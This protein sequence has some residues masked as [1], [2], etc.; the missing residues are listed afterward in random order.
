MSLRFRLLMAI[1]LALLISFS[2]G[3]ALAAWHAASS[4]HEELSSS[5]AIARQGSLAALR[6]L[7]QGPSGEAELRRMV[8]AYDGSR[9]VRAALLAPDGTVLQVST[10]AAAKKPPAWFLRLVSP[11]VKT[12]SA[13]VPGLGEFRLTAV[14][15]SEAAERWT[16]LRERLAG[17]GLFFLVAALLCSATVGRSLRPLTALTQGLA[18]VGRGELQA[19]LPQAGPPEIA[20]L[21]GAFNRMAADLRSAEAQNRRLSQQILTIA[22]EERAEIARDLHDDIGP[23]LFA[24]TNFAASIGRMIET[25]DL[26]AVPPQLRAIQDA[27]AQVQREVRDML[28][29]LHQGS[30]GPPRLDAALQELAVFWRAVRPAISLDVDCVIP[31]AVLTDQARECLFRVAQ[32]GISNAVRHG[33]PRN[34]RVDASLRNGAAILSVSD[35]GAVQTAVSGA[36]PGLGLAGMRARAASLGGRIDIVRDRGWKVSVTLPVEGA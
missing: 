32:E 19:E 9:H 23:L 7:P 16:E 5:L 36:A 4:V 27:T 1:F 8:A 28:G 20:T 6:N 10:P 24:T 15:D 30:A 2:L 11:P 17:F 12:A 22:D 34:V 25:G 14:P 21:A 33:Q 18:R 31:E 26:A 3:A 29:R 13:T 35:D